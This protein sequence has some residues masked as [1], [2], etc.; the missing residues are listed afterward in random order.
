[1]SPVS[2]SASYESDVLQGLAQYLANVGAFAY[3]PAGGYLPTDTAAVFGELPTAPDR[4]VGITLY[5]SVDAV[6]ESF[7]S[8]RVQFMFRGSANNSLDVGDAAAAVFANLHNLKGVWFGSTFL[9]QALRVSTVPLGLDANKRSLRSDNY[10]LD[11]N[12]PTTALR[13]E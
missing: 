8:V 6:Q 4:A 2:A 9:V 1:M 11:I 3:K 12:P 7:S 5:N 10:Q 13:P